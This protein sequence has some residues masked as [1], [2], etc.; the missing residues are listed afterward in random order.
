M[1][2]SP[3]CCKAELDRRPCLRPWREC[4]HAAYA[5]RAI[6]PQSHRASKALHPTCVSGGGL[7]SW[8]G[9]RRIRFTVC[10]HASHVAPTDETHAFPTLHKPLTSLHS[11]YD[12]VSN[13]GAPSRGADRV[14]CFGSRPTCLHLRRYSHSQCRHAGPLRPC[15]CCTPWRALTTSGRRPRQGPHDDT[16][17]CRARCIRIK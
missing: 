15:L 3:L 9:M 7:Q 12:T 8:F 13:T 5:R 2:L 4:S 10:P 14:E 16:G 6:V 11:C 1:L 17:Y